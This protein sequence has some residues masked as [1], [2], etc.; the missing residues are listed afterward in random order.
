MSAKK[1]FS[2]LEERIGSVM[3][4]VSQSIQPKEDTPSP[5][6]QKKPRKTYTEEEARKLMNQGKSQ[7]LGNVKMP[8]I[9]MAF[10]PANYDAILLLSS[11]YHMTYT[12]VVNTILDKYRED[13]K[14]LLESAEKLMAE[15]PSKL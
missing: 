14:S 5:G 15:L 1:D 3:D 11:V 8:R 10:T 13:N 12:K 2:K 7:G 9:T 6:S 4:V